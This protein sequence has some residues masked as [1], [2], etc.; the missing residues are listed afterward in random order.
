M[1]YGFKRKD[2]N[3]FDPRQYFICMVHPWIGAVQH[4]SIQI[5]LK[6]TNPDPT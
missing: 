2:A 1:P 6:Q 3:M 5:V 4:V